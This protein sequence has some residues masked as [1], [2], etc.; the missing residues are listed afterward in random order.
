[1]GLSNDEL[2][3]VSYTVQYTP[4]QAN[5]LYSDFSKGEPDMTQFIRTTTQLS[6]RLLVLAELLA[7]MMAGI[8]TDAAQA[9]FSGKVVARGKNDI[10]QSTVPAGLTGVT[11]ITAGSMQIWR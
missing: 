7:S 2:M 8:K 3:V 6:L 11:G 9:I 10:G 1:V 5:K 4:I